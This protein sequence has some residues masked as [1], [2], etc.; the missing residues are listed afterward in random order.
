MSTAAAAP[1]RFN[2]GQRVTIEG[3]SKNPGDALIRKVNADGTLRIKYADG[4]TYSSTDSSLA[5]LFIDEVAADG[6]ERQRGDG[7]QLAS[8]R[9][10]EGYG[11][12]KM[13]LTLGFVGTEFQVRQPR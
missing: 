4:S 6:G 3:F 13:N 2:Q 12:R 11:K 7:A 9:Y 10:D 8:S 1:R 5:T